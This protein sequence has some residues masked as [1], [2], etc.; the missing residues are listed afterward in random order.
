MIEYFLLGTVILFSAYF[1]LAFQLERIRSNKQNQE[2][3][4]AV[5]SRN[6]GEYI[7]A[8]DALRKL[9]KDKLAEMELENDLAQAAAKLQASGIPVR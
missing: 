1:A 7:S 4:A 2:L 3:L 9:P 8:I 6:V 5:L